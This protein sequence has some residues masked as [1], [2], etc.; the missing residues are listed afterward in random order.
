MLLMTRLGAGMVGLRSLLRARRPLGTHSERRGGGCWR[1]V[2]AAG[3]LSAALLASPGSAAAA[4][5][6]EGPLNSWGWDTFGDVFGRPAGGDFVAV[7]AGGYH[8]I[9]LRSD[10]SLVSWGDDNAG[11][12]SQT[13]R[14]NDFVSV[15]AG[16]WTSMAL[17]ADGTIVAWGSDFD[18]LVSQAPRGPDFA[19]IATGCADTGLAVRRDGALT[20]WGTLPA[21]ILTPPPGNDFTT[22]AAGCI[23]SVALRRDGTLVSWGFDRHGEVAGTPPGND[24]ISVAA[25]YDY[26]VA[27][28]RNGTIVAWGDDEHGEVSHRPTDADFTA[29]AAGYHHAD[30]LTREGRIVTWGDDSGD[31]DDDT[32]PRVLAPDGTGFVAVAAGCDQDVAIQGQRTDTTPPSITAPSSG[33][34]V[35]ATDP[36]GA[37]VTFSASAVDDTDGPVTVTCRPAPGTR[38]V[39]GVTVVSC[40]ASDKA[41]NTRSV[42]FFVTVKGAARQI[43]DEVD[44]VA[45]SSLPHRIRRALVRKL[46]RARLAL[47]DGKPA[48]AKRKLDA[49]RAY[50]EARYGTAIPRRVARRLLADVTRIE[51]VIG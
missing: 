2:F 25:G 34:T 16:F 26:S 11:V 1:C 30:A 32:G 46:R 43:D 7:A 33:L 42:D 50:V 45:R 44:W 20:T 19:S 18:G 15:A 29:I 24:Y 10:G 36:D 14:G 9:A 5:R 31:C 4:L 51:H 37:F 41:G 49:T 23:H 3:A 28:R 21:A 35:N 22:A 13:P 27:L 6:A 12:V 38:F 47:D 48:R 8:D 39:I 40:A 17:R